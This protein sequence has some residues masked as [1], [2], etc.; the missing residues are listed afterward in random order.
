MLALD[1]IKILDLSRGYPG[2]FG[3]WILGDLGAEV[4]N[5]DPPAGVKEVIPSKDRIDEEIRKAAWDHVHRNKKSIRL[6][7]K[8]EQGRQ[9][10]N[11][12]SEKADVILEGFR[13]GVVGKT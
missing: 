13:P 4:I 12:L 1:G 7:L 10:F 11:Q 5:I 8:S 2:S 9:I 3:T 6:N